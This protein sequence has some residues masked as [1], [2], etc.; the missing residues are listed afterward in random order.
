MSKN[1]ATPVSAKSVR[2][3]FAAGE[4]TAPT[5]ALPSLVGG[6]TVKVDGVLTHVPSPSGLVRGRLNPAAVEAFNSQ[7]KGKVYAGEKAKVDG[8]GATITLP[9]RKPNAKGAMLKRPESFTNAQVRALAGISG[10]KGRISKEA[11]VRAT[12]AVERERGWRS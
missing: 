8:E 6:K 9:L 5:E 2:A 11:L 7:V 3:A 4:F 12:E 1:I 10:R